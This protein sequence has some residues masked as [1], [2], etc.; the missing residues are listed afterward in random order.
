MGILKSTS[1]SRE[2]TLTS[3]SLGN[4]LLLKSEQ[5]V[6]RYTPAVGLR[7]I[8]FETDRELKQIR[9]NSIDA[10]Y[11]TNYMTLGSPLKDQ[12]H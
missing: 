1:G 2:A 8:V 9:D 11:A 3:R 4:C 5:A 7:M 12:G 6:L 10:Q